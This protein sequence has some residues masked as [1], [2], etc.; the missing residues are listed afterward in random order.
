MKTI[1]EYLINKTTKT[2]IFGPYDV[3]SYCL[4]IVKAEG[5]GDNK[6]QYVDIDVVKITDKNNKDITVYCDLY[7]K[8]IEFKWRHDYQKNSYKY[9]FNCPYTEIQLTFEYKKIYYLFK[10]EDGLKLL[11]SLVKSKTFD[12]IELT[13]SDGEIYGLIDELKYR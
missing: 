11:D 8:K 6:D 1:N 3:G 10:K 13:Y 7:E 2:K 12:E 4:L 9:N 5:V